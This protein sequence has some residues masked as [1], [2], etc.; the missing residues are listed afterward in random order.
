[1]SKRR[2]ITDYH[3]TLPPVVLTR[4][5][6]LKQLAQM[7]H[8]FTTERFALAACVAYGAVPHM[9]SV[10]VDSTEFKGLNAAWD[11]DGKPLPDGTRVFG[12]SAENL[13]KCLCR[14]VG[15]S[16]PFMY[17]RGSQLRACVE[18]LAKHE[19]AEVL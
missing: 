6:V 9:E 1:M 16:F 11:D 15:L 18:A 10:V 12:A 8:A 7:D 17:G 14:A 4:T 19:A 3:S 5:E 13:A 2:K